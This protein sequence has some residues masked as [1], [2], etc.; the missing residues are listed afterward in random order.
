MEPQRAARSDQLLED[1]DPMGAATCRRIFDATAG[2]PRAH[3]LGD[4]ERQSLTVEVLADRFLLARF[5][6]FLA[7]SLDRAAPEL[8]I[9]SRSRACHRHHSPARANNLCHVRYLLPEADDLRLPTDEWRSQREEKG[10]RQ[11]HGNGDNGG[12]GRQTHQTA[13]H[14][15]LHDLLINHIDDMT[16]CF[17]ERDDVA[18]Y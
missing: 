13:N 15:R 11:Q 8:D 1:G 17:R 10:D 4:Q 6:Q 3:S 16:R 2:A 14:S 18:H 9:P 5:L 12:R 7:V